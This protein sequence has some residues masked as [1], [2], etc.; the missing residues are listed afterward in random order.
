MRHVSACNFT[1]FVLHVGYQSNVGLRYKNVIRI[2]EIIVKEVVENLQ[3]PLFPVKG[4]T[5]S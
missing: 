1:V 3:F 4:Q 2:T 5:K